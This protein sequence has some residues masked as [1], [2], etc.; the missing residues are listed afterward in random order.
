MRPKMSQP[1]S[2]R[3]ADQAPRREVVGL[4]FAGAAALS[5]V[6]LITLP[7][8]VVSQPAEA[9]QHLPA[10]PAS[11]A[12]PDDGQWTMPTKN[13]AATRYSSLDQING[14]T[15]KNLRVEFTFSTGTLHGE[16]AAPI[17]VEQHDVHRHAVAEH[18]L[19][20][21][22]HEA[23][24]ADEMEIRTSD[25]SR[26]PR[27]CLLRHGQSGRCLLEQQVLLQHARWATPSRSM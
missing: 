15:V 20:A 22:S 17:V 25:D 18:R 26:R 21:G 7:G 3:C 8:A 2:T 4:A 24:R 13:Y 5:A 12:P 6:V 9:P 16:E 14:D 27:R 19:R 23:R 11:A 1:I 10:A